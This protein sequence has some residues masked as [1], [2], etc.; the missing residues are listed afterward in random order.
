MY[1]QCFNP[2]LRVKE[3][4]WE[5]RHGS[6]FRSL[7]PVALAGGRSEPIYYVGS[8]VRM[9]TMRSRRGWIEVSMSLSTRKNHGLV[10]L[11]GSSESALG[12]RVGGARCWLVYESWGVGAGS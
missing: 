3:I 12:S 2:R 7:Q 11:T 8:G 1:T 9:P 4:T 5:N 6:D 10:H